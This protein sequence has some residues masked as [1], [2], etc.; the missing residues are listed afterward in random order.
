M[1][2]FINTIDALGDDAVMDSIINRTITEFKDDRIETVSAYAFYQ[3]TNLVTVNL[4]SVTTV[5][6][7]AFY[8]CSALTTLELPN[9]TNF[10][11]SFISNC[12]NLISVKLPSVTVIISWTIDH[13]KL[14]FL[15]LPIV[16]TIQANGLCNLQSIRAIILRN[17]DVVCALGGALDN[18]VARAYFYVPAALIE[19]Y[20]IADNWSAYADRFRA[21]EDYTVDGTITG[22]LDKTK[23]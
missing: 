2:D 3:C 23:I 22:D 18:Y 13:H 4:P 19:D 12:S 15:D 11:K 9:M 17:P 5:G 6:T 8:G 10:G 14:Q 1:A 21:L 7:N 16:K 20:K